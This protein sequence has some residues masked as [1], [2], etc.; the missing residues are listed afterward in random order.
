[1]TRPPTEAVQGC[2]VGDGAEA[3]ARGYLACGAWL[4]K[5]NCTTVDTSIL[6]KSRERPEIEE[7]LAKLS[8]T[9]IAAHEDRYLTFFSDGNFSV[10]R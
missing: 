10:G 3:L 4:W 7:I 9:V 6:L 8:Y 2:S 5:F 1:M